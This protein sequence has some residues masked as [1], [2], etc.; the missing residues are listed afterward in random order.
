MIWFFH[1][2]RLTESRNKTFSVP[3][4]PEP[5]REPIFSDFNWFGFDSS[6]FSLVFGS[7]LNLRT[8]ASVGQERVEAGASRVT[9]GGRGVGGVRMAG[10]ALGDGVL[11]YL[12][13]CF[14]LYVHSFVLFLIQI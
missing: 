8:P 13:A 1:F 7:R 5:N 4:F 9:S 11:M 3:C 2:I 10:A 14:F 6:S 12:Y